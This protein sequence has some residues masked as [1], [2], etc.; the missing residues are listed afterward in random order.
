MK[1]VKGLTDK[2]V[3]AETRY[4]LIS[5]K[6]MLMYVGLTCFGASI[7]TGAVAVGG[8]TRCRSGCRGQ[9]G[10]VGL[11]RARRAGTGS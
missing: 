9:G 4:K 7:V 8:A 11:P 3:N 1:N 6:Y 2:T 5:L 10:S